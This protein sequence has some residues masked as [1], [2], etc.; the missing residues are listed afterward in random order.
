MALPESGSGSK[1]PAALTQ[2]DVYYLETYL[3]QRGDHA[4]LLAVDALVLREDLPP[5]ELAEQLK[6]IIQGV[7]HAERKV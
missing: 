5:G 7:F 3:R 1:E 4:A 6:K 2:H